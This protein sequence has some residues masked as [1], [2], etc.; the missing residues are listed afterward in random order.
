M[1]KLF[2]LSIFSS[3]IMLTAAQSVITDEGVEI[4]GVIWATRNV[5]LPNTFVDNIEDA[6]MFYQW[7]RK[8][9]WAA[10]GIVMDWDNTIPVGS[11]WE[12]IN[13]PS[14]TGWRIPTLSDIQKLLDNNKVNRIYAIENG[15]SGTWFT[16]NTSDK[17][18]FLPAAGSRS[19]TEGV[20]CLVGSV[21]DYWSITPGAVNCAYYLFFNSSGLADC[22]NSG[23]RALGYSIRCVKENTPVTSLTNIKNEEIKIYTRPNTIIV[24]NASGEVC[25]YNS[26]GLLIA[27]RA[28]A[29]HG[30]TTIPVPTA[31]IYIVRV[32][33]Y[34]QKVI[35]P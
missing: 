29:R 34:I 5:D 16:D 27:G 1:K 35:V 23:Y 17:S 33:N 9:A 32:G 14:P 15:V 13:D 26:T 6:G 30:S 12:K 19:H 18:I 2:L 31:G 25:I 24:E 20:L 22:L 7:N 10:T 3:V 11:T 4:N 28:A 21:G 8:I